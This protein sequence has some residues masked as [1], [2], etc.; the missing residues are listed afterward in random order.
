MEFVQSH[1]C[2]RQTE[3]L[4]ALEIREVN[5][6]CKCSITYP[7]KTPPTKT[8]TTLMVK[9]YQ[10]SGEPFVPP[11]PSL[12][13]EGRRCGEAV[14]TLT[15]KVARASPFFLGNG[16]KKKLCRVMLNDDDGKKKQDPDR[17]GGVLI[18]AFLARLWYPIDW[19]FPRWKDHPINWTSH[20]MFFLGG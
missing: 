4:G 16:M 15:S 11:F 13:I 5:G 19:I 1:K 17:S 9:W 8:N 2:K 6:L 7:A 14:A 12:V 18:K 3:K 10:N 20:N